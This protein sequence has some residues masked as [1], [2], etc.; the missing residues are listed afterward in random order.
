[1]NRYYLYRFLDKEKN[2]LY[3][4]RTNDIARRILKEHFTPNTHL[5][6]KCYLETECVEYAE[7][8]NESEEVAYEAILINQIRP[9]YNTQFKDDAEFEISLP[10][11]VWKPFVWEFENQLDMLKVYKRNQVSI[12]DAITICHD[13]L[14]KVA[15]GTAM[16]SSFGSQGVDRQSVLMPCTTALIAAC[17]GEYKTAYAL[18]IAQL[19]AQFGKKVF[20]INLKETADEV[21][22]RMIFSNC[23]I[24]N[25]DAYRGKLTD[26][27]WQL[28][29]D[30]MAFV[31]QLP[32]IL[33]NHTQSN[34][35][36]DALCEEIRKT[37]CDMINW[38]KH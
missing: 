10:E 33:Y 22:K 37:D 21:V 23:H 11:I 25:V 2:I 9:K 8:Q 4:G 1:M 29:M 5:P 20:Y 27:Q 7:F 19:N 12:S 36:V 35:T 16:L 24:D 34:G 31:V 28:I 32:I 38:Q 18:Q 17:S 3:I 15:D 6:S 13:Q 26:E 14:T 30:E